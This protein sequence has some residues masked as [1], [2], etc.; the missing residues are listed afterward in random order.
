MC[1]RECVYMFE[2]VYLY[3]CVRVVVELSVCHG[4]KGD[5][6]KL[7]LGLKRGLKKRW[8]VTCV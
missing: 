6:V 5:R 4:K 1:E 3:M 8:P 2:H 7:G